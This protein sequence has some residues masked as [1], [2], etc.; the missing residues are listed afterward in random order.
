MCAFVYRNLSAYLDHEYYSP[1]TCVTT[2]C[3]LAHTDI[4]GRPVI[5]R[6]IV[7]QTPC[8]EAQL[9]PLLNTDIKHAIVYVQTEF[10]PVF[11]YPQIWLASVIPRNLLE[12]NPRARQRRQEARERHQH[13]H[14]QQ[15]QQQQQQELQEQQQ[16]QQQRRGFLSFV[17]PPPS[18]DEVTPRLEDVS[19]DDNDAD[20]VHV[21]SDAEN[22]E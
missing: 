8:S 2:F 9:N 1:P 19:D 5:D 6:L 16:Q 12:D 4:V 20:A 17:E 11:N 14:Q 7:M 15:Q 10:P 18:Y 3:Q 22:E 21:V 13:H